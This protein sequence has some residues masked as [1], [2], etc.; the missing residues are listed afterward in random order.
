MSCRIDLYWESY[1]YSYCSWNAIYPKFLSLQLLCL[2]LRLNILY[3]YSLHSNGFWN[4]LMKTPLLYRH[5]ILATATY[6]GEGVKKIPKM[7]ITSQISEIKWM[8]NNF[9]APNTITPDP[10]SS[11][12]SKEEECAWLF[13]DW[14][15]TYLE[16]CRVTPEVDMGVGACSNIK[17]HSLPVSCDCFKVHHFLIHCSCD[18]FL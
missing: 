2:T 7:W 10:S 13:W 16:L 14:H 3:F 5:Y 12:W 1:D 4:C 18:V 9:F 8:C 11:Q 6:E 17:K 15:C